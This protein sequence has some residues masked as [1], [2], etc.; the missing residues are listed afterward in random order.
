MCVMFDVMHDSKQKGDRLGCLETRARFSGHYPSPFLYRGEGVPYLC[1]PCSV[2]LVVHPLS[3]TEVR[4]R[5][6]VA[7]RA[8]GFPAKP[9][10]GTDMQPLWSRGNPKRQK[11]K[12]TTPAIRWLSPA[13][14]LIWPSSCLSMGTM[15]SEFGSFEDPKPGATQLMFAHSVSVGHDFRESKQGKA[16]RAGSLQHIDA[17]PCHD[18]TPRRRAA[19]LSQ[20]LRCQKSRAGTY[21]T[22]IRRDLLP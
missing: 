21:P 20:H 9:H 18:S 16:E 8:W 14:L 5:V 1:M 12:H 3:F 7:E 6:I 19:A 13:Q 17:H 22:E 10:D 11:Q 15:G 2:C 4:R